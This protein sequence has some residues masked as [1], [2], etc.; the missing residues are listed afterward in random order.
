MYQGLL[1]VP[2]SIDGNDSKQQTQLLLVPSASISEN[3]TILNFLRGWCSVVP[4]SSRFLSH[5]W[6]LRPP[7]L[8]SPPW[9]PSREN[10]L[11]IPLPFHIQDL[12]FLAFVVSKPA[13]L[14]LPFSCA[15]S[16]QGLYLLLLLLLQHLVRARHEVGAPQISSKLR[17]KIMYFKSS[18]RSSTLLAHWISHH[19]QE[20]MLDGCPGHTV[21]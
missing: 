10:Y 5:S 12:F 21:C 7:P 19:S 3:T 6:S 15:L 1:T 16:W 4:A 11:L 20:R 14:S 13:S 18:P 9:S 17:W 2:S 8:G